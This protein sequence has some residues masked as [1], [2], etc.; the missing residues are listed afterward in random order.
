MEQGHDLAVGSL[1]GNK[2]TERIHVL[3]VSRDFDR[4]DRG[5]FGFLEQEIQAFP[6]EPHGPEGDECPWILE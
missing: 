5:R 3:N 1:L 2:Q 4:R 6:S